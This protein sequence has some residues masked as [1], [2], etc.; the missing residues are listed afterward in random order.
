MDGGVF[1]GWG[2]ALAGR[3]RK[4]VELFLEAMRYFVGLVAQGRVISVEPVFLDPHGGD[5]EGFI[6]IR[7]EQEEL[8]GLR[9]DPEVQR[10]MVKAGLVLQNLRIVGAVTGNGLNRYMRSYIQSARQVT[11]PRRG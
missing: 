4:A 10:L 11:R 3:E 9:T 5:L 2:P 7:G 1:I 8:S 6:F